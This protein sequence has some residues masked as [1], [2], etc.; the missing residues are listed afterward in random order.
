MSNLTVLLRFIS[1]FVE[2]PQNF[3]GVLVVY[4]IPYRRARAWPSGCIGLLAV[5][6]REQRNLAYKRP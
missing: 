3:A 1:N 6:A 4:K 2:N 5:C